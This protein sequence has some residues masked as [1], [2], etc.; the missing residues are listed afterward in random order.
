MIRRLAIALL[1]LLWPAAKGLAA[2]ATR[3]AVTVAES[4]GFAPDERLL[5]IHA[6]DFGMS[7]SANRATVQAL[8]QGS[9]NSA[10]VMV[11]CPWVLE[12]AEFCRTHPDAD[13]GIH[14][15]LTSEWRRYR[16]RP[17]LPFDDVPGLIDPEGYLWRDVAG[18]AAHATADEVEREL[19]AQV[20]R[21]MDLGIR[22]THLDTH[23][24]TV[25]ARPEFFRAYRKVAREFDL[26]CLLPRPH[27][28]LLERMDPAMRSAIEK[29]VA[30]LGPQADYTL[31]ELISIPGDVPLD[32]QEEFYLEAIR[33]L[34]PGITQ[35][36]IHCGIDDPELQAICGSHKRRDMDTKVF[37]GPRV[38]ELLK[39]ERVRLITWRE[40]GRR[41]KAVAPPQP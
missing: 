21:A 17:V 25:F 31:D 28:E 40:I 37:T 35:I 30:E 13:I 4:L 33:N 3:P 24:G 41:Q 9:V 7:H 1:P 20:R 10:S 2:A 11:P 29:I 19:R 23:M 38:R 6:D 27:P 39:A 18:T 16:W 34:R 32:R 8:T 22:P 36:I 15:T 26:P 14:G 5:I 12:A